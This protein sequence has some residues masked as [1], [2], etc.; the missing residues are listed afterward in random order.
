M[1]TVEK[2]Y[3]IRKVFI[4]GDLHFSEF[5]SIIRKKGQRLKNC[6]DTLNWVEETAREYDCDT[7]VYLGDFFDS[8]SLNSEELTA[9]QEVKWSSLQHFVLVGNHDMG[10]ALLEC[11]STHVLNCLPHFTVIDKPTMAGGNFTYVDFLFLPYINEDK[12][13]V[14]SK[15]ITNRI[16][17]RLIVFSHND[18]KGIQMGQFISKKG[19]NIDD[20]ESNCSLYI[21][22]HLHNGMDITDKIINLGNI[23]GQNF[24]EDAFKYEHHAMILDTETGEGYAVPNPYAFNF[25][26]IEIDSKKDFDSLSYIKKNAVLSIKCKKSLLEE[27]HTHLRDELVAEK[28][29][30]VI[31][32]DIA[33]E[34]EVESMS[35]LLSVDHIKQFKDYIIDQYQDNE[36]IIKELQE[37]M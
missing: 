30:I 9:L 28:R 19:F 22:G 37:I 5:S 7:I 18:I 27:M 6:V 20:I 4:V 2:S 29:V 1:E 31:P 16:H 24:S 15:Y 35:K 12:D 13:R 11:S 17:S 25:Y 34:E 14:L 3:A 32:D 23:T 36:Y 8:P 33:S 21:N 10:N 26:K